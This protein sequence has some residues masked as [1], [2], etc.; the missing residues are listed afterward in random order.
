MKKKLPK[1]WETEY[2]ECDTC[3]HR[4]KAA[5]PVSIL[6]LECPNCS[7]MVTFSVVDDESEL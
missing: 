2:V 6:T 7:N 5:Y 4:W 1:G 3:T